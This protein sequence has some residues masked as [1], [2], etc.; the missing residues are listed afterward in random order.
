MK[1]EGKKGKGTRRKRGKKGWE[2]EG[3]TEGGS[4][5]KNLEGSLFSNFFPM[6]RRNRA[7]KEKAFPSVDYGMKIMSLG[8]ELL[9]Y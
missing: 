4:R 1:G 8:H 7:F 6:L 5:E 2:E 3:S 9:L